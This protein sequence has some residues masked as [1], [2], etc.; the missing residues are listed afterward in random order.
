MI[1]VKIEIVGDVTLAEVIEQ[2][3]MNYCRQHT[4]RLSAKAI[5]PGSSEYTWTIIKSE[6]GFKRMKEVLF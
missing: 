5:I 1:E 4:E 6:E 3:V 2:A